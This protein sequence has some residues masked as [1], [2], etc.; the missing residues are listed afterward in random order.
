LLPTLS[1]E[2]RNMVYASTINPSN[3]R[4]SAGLPFPSK[5]YSCRHTTTTIT[6]LHRGN[7]SLL[8]LPRESVLEAAE[9]AS[10]VR[11]HATTL[12]IAIVFSGHLH[13]FEPAD[14]ARKMEAHLRKL[15]RLHPWLRKVAAY[16]VCVSWEPDMAGTLRAR[17]WKV[18]GEVVE[19]MVRVLVGQRNEVA[20][21]G[22]GELKVA[23]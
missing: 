9:Y 10:W 13:T 5:T 6:P 20:L 7:P 17:K 22:K 4:T 23:L 18:A 2:L 15:A 1:P 8:A 16:D 12:H 11:A 3:P 21:R 19:G 14:W